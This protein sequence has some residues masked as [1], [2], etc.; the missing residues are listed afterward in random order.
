MALGTGKMPISKPSVPAVQVRPGFRNRG[1]CI[2]MAVRGSRAVV[3]AGPLLAALYFLLMLCGCTQ[4][5]EIATIKCCVSN[6]SRIVIAE[7]P[8]KFVDGATVY[9]ESHAE[10]LI[11][12]E[13][14]L[15]P[16]K[17]R[18]YLQDCSYTFG[19]Q[20]M[21]TVFVELIGGHD[22]EVEPAGNGIWIK[23]RTAGNVIART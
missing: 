2:P 13:I 18:F 11:S 20:E 1:Q 3:R 19:C 7:D 22:Y 10:D 4:A 17:Y 5:A 14:S 16:G 23:D 9:D 21:G 15:R 6:I 8:T 12:A